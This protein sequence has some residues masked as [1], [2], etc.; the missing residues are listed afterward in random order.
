MFDNGLLKY[1]KTHVDK[2]GFLKAYMLEKEAERLEEY[3]FLRKLKIED[4]TH[5]YYLKY[6]TGTIGVEGLTQE[7]QE[8][9]GAEV[10]LSQIYSKAG[11]NTAIYYPAIYKDG[12]LGVISN[13]IS[14]KSTKSMENYCFEMQNSGLSFTSPYEDGYLT[15]GLIGFRNFM[16]IEAMKDFVKAHVF[17]CASGN[18]DGNPTN[19]LVDTQ[20]RDGKLD[21]ITDVK[22]IDFGNNIFRF[23]P[24]Y[25]Q[26]IEY[27]TGLGRGGLKTKEDFVEDL[28]VNSFVQSVYSTNEMAE[29]LGQVDVIETAQNIKEEIDFEVPQNL[30]DRI[31]KSF[32]TTASELI[33]G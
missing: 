27:H 22:L 15:P 30:V 14:N 7:I 16:T 20:K 17:F 19:I 32:D 6:F 2:S 33:M 24:K 18:Y 13:D 12:E 4:N 8:K 25:E 29:M 23:D 31:A 9:I 1:F 11:L 21:L 28:K 10:L 5:S 26:F 3:K